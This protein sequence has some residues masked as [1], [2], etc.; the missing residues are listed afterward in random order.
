MV[1]VPHQVPRGALQ[2]WERKKISPIVI[3]AVARRSLPSPLFPYP[4]ILSYIYLSHPTSK[5][6]DLETYQTPLARSDPFTS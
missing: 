3:Q 1:P 5:M 4:Y 2:P 6:E